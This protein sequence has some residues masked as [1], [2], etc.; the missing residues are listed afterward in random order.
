MPLYKV[1]NNA[2]SFLAAEKSFYFYW[3]QRL[4]LERRKKMLRIKYNLLENMKNKILI[5]YVMILLL[6]LNISIIS[7]NIL[8]RCALARK[9]WPDSIIYNVL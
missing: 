5:N 4:I 6:H 7:Y 9:N 2:W 8:S 3:R 1:I